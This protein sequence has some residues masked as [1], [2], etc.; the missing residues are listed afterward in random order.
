MNGYRHRLL[1]LL[2]AGVL[3]FLALRIAASP[4]E[5]AAA[6]VTFAKLPIKELTVFKDG[7]ALVAHEGEMPTD[8]N[9]NVDMDYLPTPVIGT[10]WPYSAEKRA[11]LSSVVAGRKRV[12]IERTALTLREL[13][14]ANIGAD[15]IIT[16]SGSNQYEATIV[17]LPERSAEELA[18]TSS[19][20]AAER[21][22]EKGGLVLLRT[23]EGVKV[24]S[25]DRIQE[26]TF[27]HDHNPALAEEE[28]RDLLT[29][30]LDWGKSKPGKSAKVGLFYLQK[31]VRWIPSYKVDIDGNGHAAVKLQ[32]TLLNE[33]ADLEDVSVNL[34][35]G[36][37]TF[38]FKDTLDPIALQQDLAQLSLYFQ[39]GAANQNSPFAAQFSN[40]I[41]SQ[42][43][44]SGEFR[45]GS[46]QGDNGTMEPELGE[47][48]KTED[49]FV[50]TVQH[51]SLKK[52]ERMVLSIAEFTLPYQDVF[53]LDLPFG[54]PP[55]LRGNIN[56]QQERELAKL[57]SSPKVMHKVRLTNNSKYPLT[58]AP[59][60]ISRDGRVLAQGLMTYASID[61]TVDLPV[62]TAVDFQVKKNDL[63][64]QRTPNVLREHGSQYSRIDLKGSVSIVNHRSQATEIEVSRFVLG[65]ADK[66]TNDGKLEKM[67]AF[68][69]NDCFTENPYPYWW[70]WYGWPG[71]WSH[72]NGISRISWKVTLEPNQSVDLGYEWHYFWQ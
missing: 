53:T 35:V 15:A 16:E 33:L 67:N 72:V 51:L 48:A 71:W 62:T 1:V 57:L 2:G 31:G 42:S 58:T 64:T 8:V 25:L 13:L 4:V 55:E 27:K 20:N 70:G 38:A 9:G 23:A 14:E 52:G 19:P 50:Y 11:R 65:A 39:T 22:P 26:V 56:G 30:K 46:A 54:P 28:L 59:A 5:K 61:A 10:F 41:M 37:P 44:R 12:L 69:E 32:A 49:Q 18:S 66:A 34:V 36:V 6:Q 63:E 60:L 7:H 43:I 24:V 29:L 40:A 47:T 21:L 68:E 45:G 3:G 17:A